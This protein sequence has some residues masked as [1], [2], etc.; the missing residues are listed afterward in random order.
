MRPLGMDAQRNGPT[1][2][3]RAEFGSDTCRPDSGIGAEF[4]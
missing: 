2:A 4:R 3:E 1:D